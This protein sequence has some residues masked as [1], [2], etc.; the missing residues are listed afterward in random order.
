[1]VFLILDISRQ[2]WSTV[3]LWNSYS[4]S[5]VYLKKLIKKYEIYKTFSNCYPLIKMYQNLIPPNFILSTVLPLETT[6]KLNCFPWFQFRN[7]FFLSAFLSAILILYFLPWVLSDNSSGGG[8]RFWENGTEL[9]CCRCGKAVLICAHSHQCHSVRVVS[10]QEH[11]SSLPGT[12]V[13][14]SNRYH[15]KNQWSCLLCLA[16]AYGR[17]PP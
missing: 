3:V 4:R 15:F 6:I 17:G 14:N 7:L 16:R 13:T 5:I 8:F 1:M 12:A 10:P 9:G 11:Q 2:F